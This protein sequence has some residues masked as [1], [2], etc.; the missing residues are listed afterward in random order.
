M[1]LLFKIQN[2]HYTYPDGTEA[3][4]G[5]DLEILRG[6]KTAIIGA[7]GAGKSTL[8]LHLNGILSPRQGQVFFQGHQVQY[9][10][11]YLMSLRQSVGI[12]FQDPDAQLFSSS[13]YQDISFG[14][15]N[16]KLSGKE[17]EL[18]VA[19]AM[20]LTGIAGLAS[21][22][23]HLLSHGEKKRVAIAG[24][25][26]MNPEAI[27][28]DEPTAGLDPQLSAEMLELLEALHARGKT[29]ICTTHD[30][31]LAYAWADTCVVLGNGCVAAG[32]APQKIFRDAA[33]LKA[34]RLQEPVA[35]RVF[36]EMLKH[37]MIEDQPAPPRNLEALFACLK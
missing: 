30:M 33:F 19:Q 32:G 8:L 15:V 16:M 18:R 17:I 3:L 26:A 20:E 2:L 37:K 31:D 29:L 1:D 24:V 35:L 14:P 28:F 9:T 21:K 25:L 13:V 12:V 10:R 7:N 6:S 5:I 22:P 4:K 23:T 34:N 27:I 11:A 36:Q